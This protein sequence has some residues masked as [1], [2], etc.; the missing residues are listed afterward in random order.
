MHKTTQMHETKSDQTFKIRTV[1]QGMAW[2]IY[3]NTWLKEIH[4]KHE[5]H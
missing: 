3:P 1:T 4:V 5:E 2:T